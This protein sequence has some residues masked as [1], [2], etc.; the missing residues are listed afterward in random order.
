MESKIKINMRIYFMALLLAVSVCFPAMAQTQQVYVFTFAPG[1]SDF[2]LDYANNRA[3]LERLKK[4]IH[5]DH[6]QIYGDTLAVFV[7]GY[8]ASGDGR[9][10]NLNLAFVRCNRIKSVLITNVGMRE[11]FFVTHNY[12]TAYGESK[13][14]ARVVVRIPR[15]EERLPVNIE[16]RQ[17]NG[18]PVYRETPPTVETPREEVKPAA[19][20]VEEKKTDDIQ[21][22]DIVVGETKVGEAK[23]GEAKADD[24]KADDVTAGDV[25]A[26]KVKADEAKAGKTRAGK[27]KADKVKA[28]KVK[29]R[30]PSLPKGDLAGLSLRT[31][32]LFWLAAVPNIGA[33]YR[34]SNSAGILLNGGWNHWSWKDG[35]GQDRTFFLQPEARYYIGGSKKLFVGLEGHFGQFD[36]KF[37]REKDGSQGNFAGGGITGGYRLSPGSAFDLEFSLG[38]GYTR[39][40]YETYYR[41]NDVFVR[42][43]GGLTKNF[44]GPSQA[45]IS[46]IFKL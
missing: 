3:E 6:T 43:E 28:D 23:V 35:Y 18:Q 19:T 22:P 29:D 41:S 8:A 4:R 42:R 2:S 25:K 13:D 32:L 36:F 45:G 31:N 44:F 34:L 21:V 1:S 40:S 9:R 39:I 11:E 33:E 16:R 26:D 38:L 20:A 30:Q 37:N 7:D 17:K 5:T 14:I 15:Q 27:V 46:L 12:P 10:E 24:V